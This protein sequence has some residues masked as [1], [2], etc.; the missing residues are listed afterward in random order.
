MLKSLKMMTYFKFLG[1]KNLID[2]SLLI[3]NY[4]HQKGSDYAGKL[5]KYMKNN[6]G[7]SIR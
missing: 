2:Q 5:R 4:F 1:E 3:S 7:V 6:L